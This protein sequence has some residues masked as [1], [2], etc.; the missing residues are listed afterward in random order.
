MRSLPGAA[1]IDSYGCRP[2]E[3]EIDH[4]GVDRGCPAKFHEPV[5]F[6]HGRR[7]GSQLR[8]A[9]IRSVQVRPRRNIQIGNS[10]GIQKGESFLHLRFIFVPAAQAGCGKLS[11]N[12]LEFRGGVEGSLRVYPHFEWKGTENDKHDENCGTAHQVQ[13]RWDEIFDYVKK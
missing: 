7:V 10:D 13:S 1:R 3:S 11:R 9:P 2:A 4:H 8:Q 5:I 12:S 6:S